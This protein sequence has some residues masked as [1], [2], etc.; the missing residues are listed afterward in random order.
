MTSVG[1]PELTNTYDDSARDSA[2]STETEGDVVADGGIEMLLLALAAKGD[3]RETTTTADA[4]G[5]AP[6]KCLADRRSIAIC[7]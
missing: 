1:T 4:A 6:C 2:A 5:D 7:V 3:L